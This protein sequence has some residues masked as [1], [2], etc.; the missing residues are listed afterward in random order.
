[1]KRIYELKQLCN[2]HDR[3]IRLKDTIKDAN[4]NNHWIRI[5]TPSNRDGEHINYDGDFIVE[6]ILNS[7]N[8]R[9]IEI[10]KLIE[11]EGK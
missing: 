1:V 7:I 4:K 5:Q 3:M 8:A 11:S 6:A 9:I 2:E 10:E